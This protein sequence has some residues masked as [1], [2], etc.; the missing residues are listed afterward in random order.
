MQRSKLVKNNLIAKFKKN[1]ILKR[2]FTVI[3]IMLVLIPSI[4]VGSFTGMGG[5]IYTFIFFFLIGA[6]AKYEVINNLNI[7]WYFKIYYFFLAAV[8]YFL[9]IHSVF[10]TVILNEADWYVLVTQV[11]YWPIYLIFIVLAPIPFFIE[12]KKN[13]NNKVFFI[14]LIILSC[15][16]IPFFVKSLWLFNSLHWYGFI[17][18]LILGFVAAFSDTFGLF[19]GLLIG[20][21]FIKVKLAPKLSPKKSWEG[22]IAGYL[23]S[24]LFTFLITYFF[25]A[26]QITPNYFNQITFITLSTIFLPLAAILGDLLFS[27]IK[28]NIGIKDFS[29]LIPGHGGVMDRFDSVFLTTIIF[30]IILISLVA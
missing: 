11:S 9:P 29:Q 8:F 13:K 20:G 19:A 16:L 15:F 28:R 26:Q 21:K 1:N 14:F 30:N 6:V 7:N 17:I 25:L 4:I 18:V 10:L 27:K 2:I 22:A 24:A 5:R 23:F 3:L 12:Y